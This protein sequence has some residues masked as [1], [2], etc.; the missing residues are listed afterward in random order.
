MQLRSEQHADVLE[1]KADLERMKQK[2]DALSSR[3]GT[4]SVLAEQAKAGGGV[5]ALG[6]GRA[7][8]PVAQ[9][10]EMEER[11]DNVD[12][13]FQAQ[14]EVDAALDSSGPGGLT[15]AEVEA[16]F[17]ALEGSKPAEGDL[18]GD[19]DSELQALK[20]RFRV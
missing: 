10:N 17:Q 14:R 7:S 20:Q 8:S 1:M 16:K 6:A 2:L 18:P 3:K 5:D 9:W 4:L 12:A 13:V 11:L 15:S 19:L